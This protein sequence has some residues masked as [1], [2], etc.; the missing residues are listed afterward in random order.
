MF[1]ECG[2]QNAFVPVCGVPQL[3]NVADRMGARRHLGLITRQ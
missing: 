1:I 2:T 3:R